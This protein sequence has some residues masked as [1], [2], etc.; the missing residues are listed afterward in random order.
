ME[1]PLIVSEVF[2]ATIQGEGPSIGRPCGFVRLG[3]CNQACTW[4]DE[5]MTWDWSRYDPKVELT[6]QSVDEILAKLDGMGVEMI[7]VTVIISLLVLIGCSVGLQAREKGRQAHCISNL[8]SRGCEPYAARSANL[9]SDPASVYRVAR[10]SRAP[11]RIFSPGA[12]SSA[13]ARRSRPAISP[14]RSWRS[15]C[16]A[17]KPAQ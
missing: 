8:R 11:T 17:G 16:R 10:V 3:R 13:P 6:E 2:G 14:R 7:V 5:P 12:R 1:P 9:C 4:C 15:K